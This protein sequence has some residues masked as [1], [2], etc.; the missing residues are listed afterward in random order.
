MKTIYGLELLDSVP[1]IKSGANDY[2]L[3]DTGSP[4][5]FSSSGNISFNGNIITVARSLDSVNTIYLSTQFNRKISG[6]IGMDIIRNLVMQF[7]YQKKELTVSDEQ[8][9][10]DLQLTRSDIVKQWHS[11]PIIQIFDHKK[12]RH[13]N[14]II[15]T[16]A[17]HSYGRSEI[18]Q[19]L[20]FT[21]VISDFNPSLGQFQAKSFS[22]FEYSIGNNKIIHS[23]CEYK[24]LNSHLK[25]FSVD[26]ILGYDLLK[27]VTWG[28]NLNY[29]N[30]LFN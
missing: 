15:D 1:A 3:I 13:L 4:L 27:Q 22:G 12:N 2:I 21:E 18:V 29:I 8:I 11:I 23:I 26:A 28:L 10:N 19:N 20:S 16:G 6:L 7:D 5:S 24:P 17:K 25:R 30:F 14:A 9:V